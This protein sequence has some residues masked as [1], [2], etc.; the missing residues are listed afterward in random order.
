MCVCRVGGTGGGIQLP[1]SGHLLSPPYSPTPG[2]C[3]SPR[4]LPGDQGARRVPRRR[5]P[6]ASATLPALPLAARRLVPGA[7][8]TAETATRAVF[9]PGVAV[10]A[11]VVPR[12]EPDH[13]RAEGP[14]ATQPWRGGRRGWPQRA[15]RGGWLPVLPRRSLREGRWPRRGQGA[16]RSPLARRAAAA[17]PS[18]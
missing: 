18:A 3:L 17:F 4:T 10:T 14:G 12:P 8:P 7:G 13:A 5:T 9:A 16:E 6:T 11:G 2:K 15:V 1:A